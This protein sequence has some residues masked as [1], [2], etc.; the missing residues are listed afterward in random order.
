MSAFNTACFTPG[1]APVG[2][3]QRFFLPI[4]LFGPPFE[5]PFLSLRKLHLC[6]DVLRLL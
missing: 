6:A 3:Q 2:S 4:Y 5:G 1:V